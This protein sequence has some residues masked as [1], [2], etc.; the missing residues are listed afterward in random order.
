MYNFVAK[1]RD[2]LR[3]KITSKLKAENAKLKN[4]TESTLRE[5]KKRISSCEYSL[6]LKHIEANKYMKDFGV[7]DPKLEQ[8]ISETQQSLDYYTSQLH[9]FKNK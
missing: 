9:N 6:S 4:D 5:L 3:D 1:E 8:Q 7:N 2:D